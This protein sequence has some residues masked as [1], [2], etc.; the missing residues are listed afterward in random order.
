MNDHVGSLDQQVATSMK[1][2]VGELKHDREYL[3]EY[4]KELHELNASIALMSAT[5][6]SMGKL[7]TDT[8]QLFI[9]KTLAPIEQPNL[10]PA[11]SNLKPLI[12]PVLKD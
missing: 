4:K 2:V 12:I 9:Q 11:V 1:E 6:A 7:G 8:L 3:E 5:M 10:L